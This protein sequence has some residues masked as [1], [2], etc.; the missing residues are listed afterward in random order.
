MH[1]VKEKLNL[2]HTVG[3]FGPWS[4]GSNAEKAWGKDTIKKDSS[5]M[6]AR[7]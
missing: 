6:A 4:A 3:G 7:K 1:N 2:A 5:L